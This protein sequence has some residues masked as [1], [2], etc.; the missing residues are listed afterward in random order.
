M[1][2]SAVGSGTVKLQCAT[3]V[4]TRNGLTFTLSCSMPTDATFYYSLSGSDPETPYHGPVSFTSDQLPITVKAVAKHNDYTDSETASL[5]L[6]NGEGTPEDPYLIYGSTDF[7]NFVSNVNSG[8]TASASYKLGSDVFASG[9]AAITT[10][11]MVLLM[12]TVTP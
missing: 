3:P 8:A 10:E 12:E 6:K 11:F 2:P 7:T 5:E 9:L 1:I 4:I